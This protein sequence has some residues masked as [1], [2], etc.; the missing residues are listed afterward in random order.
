MLKNK[1]YHEYTN[2]HQEPTGLRKLDFIVEQIERRAEFQNKKDIKILDIGCS[3]GDISLPLAS[4]SYQVMGIDSNSKYIEELNKKSN[5][6][7]AQFRIQNMF[8]GNKD[9]CS[10]C[11]KYDFI[12]VSKTI[13]YINE[14]KG[15][16]K[17]LKNNLKEKGFLIL[18]A[19][20]G[21]TLEN[22][23]KKYKAKKKKEQ[24]TTL[25]YFSL[26]NIEKLIDD[27]GFEVIACKNQASVFRQ[28]Y[29]LFLKYI[30]SKGSSV[31]R[32]LDKLD[33]SLANITPQ[34]MVDGWMFVIKKT[35]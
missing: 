4:L 13:E 25:H 10:L 2:L 3:Q 27:S 1:L 19:S 18:T 33:S 9:F 24:F 29:S 20:N 26:K 11:E 35:R 12:I 31:F 22:R 21:R 14:P 6:S 34:N 17:S 30:L 23:I 32:V 5:F 7:N 8:V 16:L 15:F 28:A